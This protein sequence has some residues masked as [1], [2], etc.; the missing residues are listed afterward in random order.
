MKKE[1]LLSNDFLKQFT[2]GEELNDF[3]KQIQKR[4]IEKILEGELDSHLGYDKHRK[5]DN[6]NARNGFTEKK[7]RTSLGESKI[8]VPRD[9]DASFNPMIVPK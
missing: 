7:L 4:G 5:S 1:D 6:S 2:S 3:L 8:Q 9:R